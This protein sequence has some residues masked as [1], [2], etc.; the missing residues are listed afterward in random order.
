M[1]EQARLDGK[2]TR[3]GRDPGERWPVPMVTH[4]H[5]SEP[6]VTAK[7]DGAPEHL[8]VDAG[9]RPKRQRG[10]QRPNAAWTT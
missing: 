9:F 4:Q 2:P 3:N 5:V 6:E 1:N 7:R 10:P 8:E